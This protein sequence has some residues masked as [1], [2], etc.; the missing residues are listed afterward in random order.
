MRCRHLRGLLLVALL[1]GAAAAQQRP[2]LDPA[3]RSLMRPDAREAVGRALERAAE[4]P[5]RRAGDPAGPGSAEPRRDRFAELALDRGGPGGGPRIGVLVRLREPVAAS[6][7]EL[8]R[9]GARIGS[10]IGRIATAR[11][12]LEALPR[13]ADAARL[14]RID[15]ARRTSLLNDSSMRAV[16]ATEVRRRDGDLWYGSAGHGV[17]VGIYDTGL[18]YTHGDFRDGRGRSRV[19]G[20]WDHGQGGTPPAGFGYGHYCDRASLTDGGCPARDFDGHGTHVLGTAAG[21]GS[22][23]GDGVAYR[24]AGVAPAAELLVVR[25]QRFT[26]DEIVDGVNWIFQTA[27]ALGRPAVV[28]LSLGLQWGGRDGSSL[29]EQALDGLSGA[30]R[31]IVVAA[32]NEASNGNASPS[33]PDRRV[34]AMALPAQ[35]TTAEFRVEVPSIRP[36]GGSCNDFGV[37]ELW[38]AGADRVDVSVVRPD[39][40][41]IAAAYRRLVAEP[42]SGGLVRIDNASG[43]PDPDNGDHQAVIEISDCT[44]EGASSGPPA[45]G[46]WIAR[47]APTTAASGRPIHLWISYTRYGVTGAL[48]GTS[49]NFDNGYIVSS[50]GTAR[51]VVTVGAY[52]TRLDWTSVGGPEAYAYREAVGD[53]AYFSSGGPTRDGRLKPEV[54]APGRAIFSALS[55]SAYWIPPDYVATDGLH[56]AFQGTSMST[57]HVTGAIAAML[58]HDPALTPA[59]VK[60]V[61]QR[62][63]RQDAYTGRSFTGEDTGSPN[64]QWGYGKL[65]VRAA[66]EDLVDPTLVA[67]V[68][69]VPD[70][71]SISPGR[72]VRLRAQPYNAIGDTVAADGTWSSSDP[73]V[74]TVDADGTVTA[75]ALGTATITAAASGASGTATITVVPPIAAVALSPAEA[76]LV[77]GE[78]TALTATPL[79]SAGGPLAG[80]AVA[81]ASTDPLVAT[82]DSAGRVSSLA[83]GATAIVATAEEKSDTARIEVV[84]PSTL[85]VVAEAV[86]VPGP[87]STEKD[88]RIVLLRLR[89]RVD[90]PEAVRVRRIGF[91]LAGDDPLARAQLVDDRAA[92]ASLDEDDPVLSDRGVSLARGEETAIEF[93]PAAWIVAAGDSGSALLALELSGRS[94]NGTGFQARYEPERLSTVGVRSGRAD[95]LDQADGPVAGTT[96]PTSVLRPDEVFALSENPVL[97]NRVIF[98]F[99][100][101]PAVAAVYTLTGARVADLL[102]RMETDGR[103]EWDLTNDDGAAVAPGIYLVAFS[104]AGRLI[105]RKLIIVRPT[106]EEE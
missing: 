91:T 13:L 3:L 7:G 25:G 104:V 60:A 74:A 35:G 101:R 26:E 73:A 14:E 79:D 33:P 30:G 103:V 19:L 20:L 43:G 105:T 38:Y 6:L 37:I 80:R 45:S 29:F 34:H 75:V 46:T 99:R 106:D 61:L 70:A 82:V 23:A 81:W 83:V 31:I 86:P 100:E 66:I 41:T 50:P 98:N 76:T 2:H 16:R 89:L 87:E 4:R 8:R 1:P 77:A 85:V 5:R 65:D 84:A 36:A 97:S 28:N 69:V 67:G 17:I 40:R 57:P 11:V 68:L 92:N 39:G 102:R 78:D 27:A 72:T 32:G 42:D 94:P 21:D 90:G 62:T 10:V 44:H 96:V 48:R 51:E 47:A 12:P 22:A 52:V 95:R 15:A 49:A 64:N 93:R 24:Y 18:D 63:A 55:A 88:H 9:S 58:Q 59:A 56:A 53:I 71:D 54:A